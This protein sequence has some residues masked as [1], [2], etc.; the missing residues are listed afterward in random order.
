MWNDW[1][2]IDK[3]EME[4]GKGLNKPREKIHSIEEMLNI[5]S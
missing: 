4:K 5:V 1:L 3:V 2:K